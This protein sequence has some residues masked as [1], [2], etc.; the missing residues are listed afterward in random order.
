[1]TPSLIE[2]WACVFPPCPLTTL[3]VTSLLP[4]F[5]HAPLVN[6]SFIR[7][8]AGANFVRT[9]IEVS[10]KV[11]LEAGC[12]VSGIALIYR[13]LVKYPYLYLG[14]VFRFSSFLE[15]AKI[16]DTKGSRHCWMSEC[17]QCKSA[18]RKSPC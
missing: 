5:P 10:K 13:N 11:S 12:Y 6:V 7:H 15:K 9:N 16:V 1:M 18:G 2:R 3:A 4:N 8:E 17:G 14:V